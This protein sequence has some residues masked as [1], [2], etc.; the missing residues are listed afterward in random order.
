MHKI[1]SYRSVAS[2]LFIATFFVFVL[3]QRYTRKNSRGGEGRNTVQRM[4]P[5]DS[6]N[7]FM[8]DKVSPE[9]AVITV[10]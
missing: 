3:A 8:A 5:K 7:P 9:P 1:L 2:F 4:F 10:Q 6:V